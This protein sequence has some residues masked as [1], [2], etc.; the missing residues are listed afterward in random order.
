MNTENKKTEGAFTTL[1]NH[2]SGLLT[3]LNPWNNI[4]IMGTNIKG[5]ILAG[6][7]VAIIALPLALAFG[8]GSGLGA[9]TGIWGAIAGGIIGGLFGGSRI[10]VSGPTGPKMVQLAAIMVGFRLASGEPN[11]TA[12]FSIIFLSGL[13]LVGISFLKISKI[14]YLTPYSVVA[15]FMCGIGVIV[16]LLEFDTF[17][18]VEAPHSVL[19]AIHNIPHA[20]RNMKLE[21]LMVSVPSIIILFGWSF[22]TKYFKKLIVIPSPLIALVVGT[23]ISAYFELDIEYIGS[24]PTGLPSLYFPEFSKFG[25][26]LKPAIS[27]AGLAIFDSLLTCIVN[28]QI[29]GDKHSSD[30]EVFGQGLANMTAGIVGGLTTATATMRSV[31]AHAAGGRTPL[32]SVIHG[33]VLLTLVLGLGPLAEK[34]PMPVLAAILIKVGIDII[35]YRILP[36][37]HKLPLNDMLVFWTVLIVTVLDDLLVGMSVGVVF[38]VIRFAI[39]VSKTYKPTVTFLSNIHHEIINNETDNHIKVLKPNGPM[40]FGSIEPLETTYNKMDDH[41][42][43]IICLSEVTMIDLSGA[44]GL[45]DLIKKAKDDGS[46]VILSSAPS[47][48]YNV[49]K[50]I[51]VIE[52]I[53]ENLYFQ[54]NKQ[55][56]KHS[57][58]ME[59]II[60]R[61]RKVGKHKNMISY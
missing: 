22:V 18:G 35:D 20:I 31:A 57:Q 58:G 17:F 21:A 44:Y 42:I 33:L 47:N 37:L 26:Y 45:E 53:G 38:A 23:S 2:I 46:H 36:V 54:D 1:K 61:Q 19:E 7:T 50:S 6:I 41:D 43:L 24:I 55:A 51:K 16:I 3:E 15:G 39:E 8:V 30:R 32:A 9:I 12:A 34:I 13:I 4:K 48:V 29:S 49:L 52:H 56:I 10:G 11:L 5:D 59:K 40:F 14:I 28:D 60:L 25:E 27:L